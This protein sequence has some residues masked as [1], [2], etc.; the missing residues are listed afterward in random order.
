MEEAAQ[1]LI[2]KHDFSSF[3][4]TGSDIKNPVREIFSLDIKRFKKIDF[5]SARLEGNFLK[6][7]I[8]ANGFLRHMVR[9]IVG[10][11]VEIGRGRFPSERIKEILDSKDRRLAG[12]TAPAHGLFLERIEY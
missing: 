10:T 3:M 9:N 7:S 8:E 12:P 11:M 6:I 2:G 4:G 5:I 1:T